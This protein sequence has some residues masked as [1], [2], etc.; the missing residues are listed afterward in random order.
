MYQHFAQ[1]QGHSATVSSPVRQEQQ[2]S[3]KPQLAKQEN[4]QEH[5]ALNNIL[6]SQGHIFAIIG[7]S[8]QEHENKRARED[9]ERRVHTVS[10][11]VP[12]N[13]LVWSMVPIT[14]DESDFQVRD[15]SYIDTFV[16]IANIAGFIVH[17]ILVD[18]GSST[19]TIHNNLVDNGSSADILFIKPFEQMNLDKRTLEPARNSLFGFGGEKIDVLGKKTI[20]VSFVEGEKVRTKMITFD[21]VNMDYPYT[22]IFNRGVL[23]NSKW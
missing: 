18:N 14:F 4:A 2:Q 11:K 15:F 6:P 12:L 21:I 8:N 13:M 1:H 17:N 3:S 16:A 7:G 22:A 10:P 9:Y 23:K 5:Q 20:L 19:N